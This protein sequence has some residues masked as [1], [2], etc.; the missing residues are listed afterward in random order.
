MSQLCSIPAPKKQGQTPDTASV[1]FPGF[2]TRRFVSVAVEKKRG[3]SSM[4]YQTCVH[5]FSASARA[6]PPPTSYNC[7]GENNGN[8]QSQSPR[9]RTARMA[10]WRANTAPR[11]ARGNGSRVGAGQA[12]TQGVTQR[13]LIS[14]HAPTMRLSNLLRALVP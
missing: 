6:V 11:I 13:R 5:L 4:L 2:S 12:L 14:M 7:R 10:R 1:A 3:H 8:A 9:R